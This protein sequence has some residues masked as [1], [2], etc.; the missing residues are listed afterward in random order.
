[1][2][3]ACH[4][5]FSWLIDA[6]RPPDVQRDSRGWDQTIRGHIYPTGHLLFAENPRAEGLLKRGGH[7]RRRFAPTDDGNSIDR[8]QINR[9]FTDSQRASRDVDSVEDQPGRTDGLKASLPNSERILSKLDVRAG[10]LQDWLDNR[11]LQTIWPRA[12]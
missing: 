1:M 9:L 6:R 7:S 10:H 5:G 12:K 3:N 4:A 2:T 8:V 11:R